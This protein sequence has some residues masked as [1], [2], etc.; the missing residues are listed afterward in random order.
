M[1]AGDATEAA[2]LGA[3]GAATGAVKAGDATEAAALGADGAATGA[4]V[5]GGAATGG[6][7]LGADSCGGP[8]AP[9]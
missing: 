1:K 7:H 2:A 3:G 4:V 6:A 8:V 9:A 5:V